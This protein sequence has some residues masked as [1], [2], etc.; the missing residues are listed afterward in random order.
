MF[1]VP[2]IFVSGDQQKIHRVGDR[3]FDTGARQHVADGCLL[4]K[5][6]IVTTVTGAHAVLC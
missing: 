5:F 2:F 4:R 1:Q 6:L 3:V